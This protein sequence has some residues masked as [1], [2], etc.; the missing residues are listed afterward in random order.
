M[1]AAEVPTVVPLTD[2]D[3][4]ATSPA[5]AATALRPSATELAPVE[6]AKGPI[7]TE[8]VP[9]GTES[10]S[11]EL[12]WKY[13]MPAPFASAFRVLTLLL[14]LERP[15]DSDVTPLWALLIPVDAEVESEPTLLC[16]VLMP[17]DA[18]VESELT[19]L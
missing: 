7:A 19:L 17:V 3:P 12:A 14:T 6:V 13:L 1:V 16:V 9:V 18:E 8:L 10:P 11:E 5:F 2:P 15:V 4:R